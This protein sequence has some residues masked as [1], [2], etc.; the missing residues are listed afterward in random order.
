MDGIR[1]D[2]ILSARAKDEVLTHV[3][4]ASTNVRHGCTWRCVRERLPSPRK[5]LRLMLVKDGIGAYVLITFL[6]RLPRDQRH[7][8]SLIV[9]DHLAHR[10]KIVKHSIET[11]ERKWRLHF[12]PPYS[13]ELDPDELA[14]SDVKNN[15]VCRSRL[16]GPAD[17]HRAVVG[18]LRF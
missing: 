4:R 17:L 3:L 16:E 8:T 14:W 18:R 6:K 5:A 1:I 2:G 9:D 11:P 13:P 7:P 15:A 10:A 12:S